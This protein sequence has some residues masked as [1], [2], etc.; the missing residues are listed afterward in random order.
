MQRLFQDTILNGHVLA[1][2]ERRYDMTLLRDFKICDDKGIANDDLKKLF[3]NVTTNTS[4]QEENSAAWFDDFMKYSL[5]S[6]QFG[7]SLID[8]G[9]L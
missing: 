9:T 3:R 6:P 2:L 7:Y 1:C 8:L 5:Q 4:G